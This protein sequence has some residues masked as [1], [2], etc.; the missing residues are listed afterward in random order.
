MRILPTVVFSA[1]LTTANAMGANIVKN[2]TAG[3]TGRAESIKGRLLFAAERN[4]P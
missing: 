4:S 1:L 2:T 3:R